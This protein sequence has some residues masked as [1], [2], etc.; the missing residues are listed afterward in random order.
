VDED[1]LE[2]LDSR[3][4][5]VLDAIK[6]DR[7]PPAGSHASPHAFIC[8]DGNTYWVKRNAQQ[9]LAAELIAG[10]VGVR[11]GAAPPTRI[12][13]VGDEVPL[14]ADGSADHLRGIGVGMRDQ[15]GME[16]LRH[17]GHV[18]PGGQL[19]PAK[20]D[21]PSRARV[22]ALQTWLG[23]QDTQILV[24]L[25]DGKLMSIDHGEWGADLSTGTDPALMPTPG[26]PADFGRVARHVED[27]LRRIRNVTDEHLLDDVARMPAGAD[28]NAERTRRLEVARWLGWRRDRLPGVIRAWRTS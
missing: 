10:R 15:P 12:V 16:N 3:G 17:L 21:I 5:V 4:Y 1:R 22:L 13:R 24:D 20:I 25:R 9:G 2:R 14:P 26:V 11:A 23:V 18:L 28:W 8:I 7:P 27:A 6:Y 19:D